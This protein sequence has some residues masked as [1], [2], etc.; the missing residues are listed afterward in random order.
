MYLSSSLLSALHDERVFLLIAATI[1]G[2]APMA[3]IG[4]PGMVIKESYFF[5]KIIKQ[6]MPDD[7]YANLQKALILRPALGDLIPGTNGLRK[8]RWHT[9]EQGKRGG[10]RIIYYWLID[11]DQIY[12]LYAYSKSKSD[13]LSAEQTKRLKLL[14]AE[15]FSDG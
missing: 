7:V 10:V 15:E 4:S 13:K 5:T 1:D 12:M 9:K 3:Y 6:L 2:G 11:D 14:V 8:V